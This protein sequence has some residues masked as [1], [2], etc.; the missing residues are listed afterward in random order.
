MIIVKVSPIETVTTEILGRTRPTLF[1]LGVALFSA[2]AGSY[3]IIHGR[4]GT[5]IG[6]AIA[7]ALMPPL[8]VVGFGFATQRW[9][10]FGG[11]LLLFFTNFMTIALTAAVVARL[12]G[13]SSRLSPDQTRLQTIGIIVAFFVLA[14]PLGYSLREIAW[15]ATAQRQA[16]EAIQD[17]FD[18]STRISDLNV[19]KGEPVV[20]T[21]TILTTVDRP[22]ARQMIHD[23]LARAWDLPVDIRLIQYRVDTPDDI[24]AREAELAESSSADRGNS[25][26]EA[27]SHD[28]ALIAGVPADSVLVDGTEQR[29]TVRTQ[30]LPGATLATYH[31]L[32]RRLAAMDCGWTIELVPPLLALPAIA[33]DDGKPTEGGAAA[34]ATISWAAQ[35]T[36]VPVAVGVAEDSPVI[37]QLRNAGI[38]A[39]PDP[40]LGSSSEAGVRWD[41][42][43]EAPDDVAPASAPAQVEP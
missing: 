27:I 32:E 11:A 40:S 28:L 41:A 10:V 33:L 14:I 16:R 6:V 38:I 37:T 19:A 22:D 24:A 8:A 5:I 2:M 42:R 7:T 43:A 30:P 31:A 34:M 26:R 25:A 1:D 15:A 21:A 20:V 35:R 29:A 18:P 4:A 13:F 17:A 9:D 39:R 3:A 12:Y 36:G 23:R